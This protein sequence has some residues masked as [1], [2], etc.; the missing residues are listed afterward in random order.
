MPILFISAIGGVDLARDLLFA[1]LLRL[2]YLLLF[3]PNCSQRGALNAQM[4][5]E[6]LLEVTAYLWF[7]T[8][9]SHEKG[10][11]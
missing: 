1:R 6:N 5:P 2:L 11:L 3:L 8:E 7:S 4:L 10:W 9:D